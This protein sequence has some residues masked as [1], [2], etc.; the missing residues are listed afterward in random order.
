MKAAIYVRVSDARQADNTSLD[1]QEQFCREW[2]ARNNVQVVKVFVEAGASAKSAN[3]PEF[4]RMFAWLEANHSGISHVVCDKWDRFSR[5]MDDA[6][7]YRVQLKTWRV[8]LVSATQ[9]VTDDPAGRLLQNILQSFGQFDNEQRAERSIRGMRRQAEAGRFLNPAP[10]GYC[11]NGKANPSMLVDETSAPMVR[12]MYE[13]IGDGH[14]LSDALKWARLH[15]L[16]GKRGGD[17]VIQ[18]ASKLM[19]NPAYYGWL[20][21][22]SSGISMQGDWEPLVDA[23][24]WSRVQLALSGRSGALQVVH[25][26]VNDKYVLRGVIVCD[27]CGHL[28][29]ASPS[30]SKSG[31]RIPY[32]HCMKR[33]HLYINVA[34]ADAWFADLLERLIPN[35]HRL[36]VVEEAFR[37]AWTVKNGSAAADGERLKGQLNTLQM[38]KRRLLGLVQDGVITQGDFQSEYDPLGEQITAV[39]AAIADSEVS[40]EPLDV[41]TA[42]GYL[43]HLLYNQHLV[44]IQADAQEKRRIARLIFPSGI[45]CSKGGFGTPLTHSLFSM[46]GDES[47]PMEGLVALSGIEPEF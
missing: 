46:L 15:G 11:N 37:E 1:A 24:L 36:L 28:A 33:G 39:E 27:S 42:W 3:R 31:K 12:G 5:S 13:R 30:R 32:Y 43:E 40:R 18:T 34:K 10:L 20:E 41:D 6:V 17:I 23:G 9:P 26:A 47:I 25:T 21:R 8:E 22:P 45:R 4:Q 38:R 44:W 19:R 35:E 14:S 2:C 7:T 16:R 29:T